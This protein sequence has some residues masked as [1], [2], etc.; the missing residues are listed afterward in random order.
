MRRAFAATKAKSASSRALRQ[1]IDRAATKGSGL[2]LE[3]SRWR[4]VAACTSTDAASTEAYWR[5]PMS[6]ATTQTIDAD[7]ATA[8]RRPANK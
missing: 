7:T 3:Q 2:R 6:R 4:R 1:S 8:E 5:T